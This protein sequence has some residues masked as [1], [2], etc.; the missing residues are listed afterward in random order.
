[1]INVKEYI[2]TVR[3]LN[4][5]LEKLQGNIIKENNK[6]IKE[7]TEELNKMKVISKSIEYKVIE[8]KE[9]KQFYIEIGKL[10]DAKDYTLKEIEGRWGKHQAVFLNIDGREIETKENHYIL[11][12]QEKS[13]LKYITKEEYEEEFVELKED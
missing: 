8:V 10:L 12:N 9:D 3:K 11:V 13:T 1:M 4:K 2:E 7:R 6:E 5:N